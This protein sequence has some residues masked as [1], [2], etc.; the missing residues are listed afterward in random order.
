MIQ[1]AFEILRSRALLDWGVVLRGLQGVPCGASDRLSG[2]IVQSY[3]AS[4]LEK[5][6]AGDP[7]FDSI[8]VLA[9]D[10]TL[11]TEEKERLVE[12]ICQAY[13]VDISLATRKWRA[14]LIEDT[15]ENVDADPM[16]GYIQLLDIWSKLDWPEDAPPSMRKNAKSPP[17]ADFGS[18]ATFASAKVEIQNWL[19]NE[20]LALR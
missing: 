12:D 6:E 2:D 13:D 20:F 3:A 17:T 8:A 4:A 15:V 16:Y 18:E 11:P 9:L 5:V 14:A 1:Q 19:K 7:A 10:A